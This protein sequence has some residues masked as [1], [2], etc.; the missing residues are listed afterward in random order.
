MI[1]FW[2]IAALLAAAFS[3]VV[4]AGVRRAGRRTS[5]G[6]GDE[7]AEIERLHA[8]GLLDEA[9]RDQARTE[10]ARRWLSVRP[11]VEAKPLSLSDRPWT[12]G[13]VAVTGLAALALYL[14]V[15]DPGYDDQPYEARVDQWATELET[16]EAPQ[17]AAVVARRTRDNPEDRQAWEMLGVARFEAGDTIGSASAFRRALA[18]DPE[19]PRSWARLGE[20]MTRA[21]QGVVGADA[22]A[23]FREALARDP[24]QPAALYFMGE[25]ALARGDAEAVRRYWTPLM[26]M[27]DTADPRRA[28]L[29]SRLA[30]A[31]AR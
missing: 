16:L 4:M 13:A 3:A 7:M 6:A 24:E 8:Q 23:A 20:A 9:A 15:G 28:D 12:L 17:I 21:Q 29:E 26:G 30:Q 2:T 27:L 14:V 1:G 22:E 31:A 5:G 18:I 25:A 11:E 10:T 19:D